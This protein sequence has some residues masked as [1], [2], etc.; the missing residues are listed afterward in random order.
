MC[1][2]YNKSPSPFF[3][4]DNEPLTEL[5]IKRWASTFRAEY[6]VARVATPSKLTRKERYAHGLNAHLLMEARLV[7]NPILP[8]DIQLRA[9]YDKYVLAN[10]I[11]ACVCN[12]VCMYIY[13]YISILVYMFYK[14]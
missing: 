12:V 14:Y 13:I 6:G 9:D 1:I 7:V 10:Y 2:V 5:V 11:I 3:V 8:A 4:V